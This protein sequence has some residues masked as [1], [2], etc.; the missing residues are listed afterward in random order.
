ML[1]YFGALVLL[2]SLACSSNP[3]FFKKD[4]KY[5][6][7]K[8]RLVEIGALNQENTFFVV[9]SSDYN[10]KKLIIDIDK[11]NF[12]LTTYPFHD[13]EPSFPILIEGDTI[14]LLSGTTVGNELVMLKKNTITYKFSEDYKLLELINFDE[15]DI[16]IFSRY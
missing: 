9:D 4:K 2:V 11:K 6:N 16:M 5:L 12:Y 15:K 7:G 3:K 13:F 1:K 14:F 8:W 10:F